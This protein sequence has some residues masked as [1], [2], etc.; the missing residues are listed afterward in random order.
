M[1]RICYSLGILVLIGSCATGPK[2]V[3]PT[4]CIKNKATD[5]P[6]RSYVR[7]SN[8]GMNLIVAEV[9]KERRHR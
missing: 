7:P 6:G 3:M 2:M 5:T 4:N 1:R 9:K 8:S